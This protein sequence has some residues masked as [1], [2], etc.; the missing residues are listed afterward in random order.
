M[1]DLNA[2]GF[3]AA[4]GVNLGFDHDNIG[5]QP[6]RA[7]ARLFF[8]ECDFTARRGDAVARKNRLGLV[9]VDLHFESIWARDREPAHKC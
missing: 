8:G 4:T 3:A 5:S 7:F 2:A 6:G 9:L 1:R